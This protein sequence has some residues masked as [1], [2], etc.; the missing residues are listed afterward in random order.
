MTWRDRI[1]PIVAEIIERIGRDDPKRLKRAL[2]DERP[3]WV[4]DASHQT[5]IWRDEVNIQLGRKE[6]RQ[7]KKQRQHE[8]ATGQAMLFELEN[9]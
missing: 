7:A 3:Y 2:I 9:K 4:R 8:Q 6:H 1:R 5:K